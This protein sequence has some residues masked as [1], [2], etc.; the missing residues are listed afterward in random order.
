MEVE[1]T[2]ER[3]KESPS[4]NPIRRMVANREPR[5]KEKAASYPHFYT[6]YAGRMSHAIKKVS[7]RHTQ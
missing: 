7:N 3:K 6:N 5:N 1:D 4:K 2:K